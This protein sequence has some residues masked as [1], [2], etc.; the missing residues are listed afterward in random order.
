MVLEEQPE[1]LLLMVP[2]MA[3]LAVEAVGKKLALLQVMVALAALGA[4]AAVAGVGAFTGTTS[5]AGGAGGD[6]AMVI[7]EYF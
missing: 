4:A 2:F 7:V 3:D 1:H 6:G 5:G